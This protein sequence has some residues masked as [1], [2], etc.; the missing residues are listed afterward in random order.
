MLGSEFFRKKADP[1][2]ENREFHANLAKAT[3]MAVVRGATL[4]WS[5]PA[6]PCVASTFSINPAGVD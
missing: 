3:R 5:M 6:P 1:A 2:A 4:L